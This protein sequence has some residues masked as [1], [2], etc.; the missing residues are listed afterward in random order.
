MK[1]I[2]ALICFVAAANARTILLPTSQGF[3]QPSGYWPGA[4]A[5]PAYPVRP[6]I[7][8]PSVV[9]E[10]EEPVVVVVEEEEAPLPCNPNIIGVVVH[11]E[12]EEQQVEEAAVI[13][14]RPTIVRP[15]TGGSFYPTIINRPSVGQQKPAVY[16]V[17][18]NQQQQRPAITP[19]G[20]VVQQ[21]PSITPVG[22]Q[23]RPS[24]T[25]VGPQ[26][27]PSIVPAR[28]QIRPA[29]RPTGPLTRPAIPVEQPAPCVLPQEEIVE[30][31][32]VFVETRPAVSRPQILPAVL[33]PAVSVIN[34]RP[35]I[36]EDQEQVVAMVVES[37]G[38]L[39]PVYDWVR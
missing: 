10:V 22:P 30:E 33:P 27:R 32:E 12:Q 20:P 3:S 34:T 31:E 36:Q 24:I 8:R 11:D 14:T 4:I 39:R 18:P 2:V 16:P 38:Q 6:A 21:R 13:Q 28:P 23:I 1:A 37:N 7:T 29:V 5:K 17:Y 15:V 35:A 19:T 9:E 25:P 26:I